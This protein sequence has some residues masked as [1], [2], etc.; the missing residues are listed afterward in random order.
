V[1]NANL[2]PERAWTY[3]GGLD[4]NPGARIHGEVT[5]FDRRVRDGID[6]YRTSPTALWQAL[7]IDNLQFTGIESS[8]R[9]APAKGQTLDL[10]YTWLRGTQDTVPL[11]YT[12]YTFNYPVNSAVA[13]WQGSVRGRLAVRSRLGVLERIG[14]DPYAL[15]EVYAGY[16]AG[17][18]HPFLQLSN[19]SGAVYQEVLG[20]A[21]PG[22]TVIGGMEV[23]VRR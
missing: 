1:G 9:L 12:R 15:W 21:M 3:E 18:I 13:A 7:N 11:G 20:V 19:L 5:V 17:R 8:F 4:W 10:R 6:Y 16:T 14:R 22:R 23:V 2:R